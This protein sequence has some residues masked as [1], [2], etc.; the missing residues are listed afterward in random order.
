MHLKNGGCQHRQHP[1]P[2]IVKYRLSQRLPRPLTLKVLNVFSTLKFF[3]PRCPQRHLHRHRRLSEVQHHQLRY[4]LIESDVLDCELQFFHFLGLVTNY[5]NLIAVGDLPGGTSAAGARG[6]DD[7]EEKAGW[8]VQ[9]RILYPQ[10]PNGEGCVQNGL[11]QPGGGSAA[12][13]LP[14]GQEKIRLVRPIAPVDFHAHV[15][16]GTFLSGV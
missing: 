8:I 2:N 7:K 15:G 10:Y 11:P 13:M 16:A 9:V 12:Q 3:E 14:S 1:P 4:A 6:T 5:K